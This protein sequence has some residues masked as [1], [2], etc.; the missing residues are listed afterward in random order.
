MAFQSSVYNKGDKN[1][2]K[3]LSTLDFTLIRIAYCVLNAAEINL[4]N[5]SNVDCIG[6][7]GK[8]RNTVFAGV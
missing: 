2:T 7:I 3:F 5:L 8:E 4:I 1:A 6:L